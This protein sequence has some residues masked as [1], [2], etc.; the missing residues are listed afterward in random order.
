MWI[1]SL[2][3]AVWEKLFSEGCFKLF[4]QCVTYLLAWVSSTPSLPWFPLGQKHITQLVKGLSFTRW[5]M[6]VLRHVISSPKLSPTPVPWAVA[7]T[8]AQ[9]LQTKLHTMSKQLKRTDLNLTTVH[10]NIL[11]MVLLLFKKKKRGQGRVRN[12]DILFSLRDINIHNSPNW[13]KRTERN[14]LY[15]EC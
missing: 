10:C 11:I 6:A 13:K 12:E 5:W 14:K 2:F 4:H 7:D 15:G 8:V 1:T 9:Q 3:T